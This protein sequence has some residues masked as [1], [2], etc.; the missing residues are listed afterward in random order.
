MITVNAT[1][2]VK[3][4]PGTAQADTAR[5]SVNEAFRISVVHG[6][7]LNDQC[8]GS[9]LPGGPATDILRLLGERRSLKSNQDFKHEICAALRV[10]WTRIF[11]ICNRLGRHGSIPTWTRKTPSRAELLFHHCSNFTKCK[12]LGISESVRVRFHDD[13]ISPSALTEGGCHGSF[14]PP[15]KK[16]ALA[17][18][19]RS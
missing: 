1:V 19:S 10:W 7:L 2:R 14:M 3:P 18:N 9:P 15:Q 8:P 13:V 17:E 5:E 11:D 6:G 4:L 12:A 16:V